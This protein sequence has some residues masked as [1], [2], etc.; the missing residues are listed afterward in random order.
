MGKR[1]GLCGD[2]EASEPRGDGGPEFDSRES[3]VFAII[4]QLHP[5]VAYYTSDGPNSRSPDTFRSEPL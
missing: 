5:F 3:C 2:M 1:D 4:H